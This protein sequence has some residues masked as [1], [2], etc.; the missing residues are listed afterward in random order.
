LCDS[1]AAIEKPILDNE[2][3]FL[4][5]HQLLSTIWKLHNNHVEAFKTVIFRVC[6]SASKFW[7][8]P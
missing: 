5:S 4:S 7:S 1:L 8:T 3:V 2:K 6:F